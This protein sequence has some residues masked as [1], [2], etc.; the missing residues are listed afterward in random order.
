MKNI[1]LGA[2]MLIAMVGCATDKP[3][4]DKQLDSISALDVVRYSTPE[5][6]R[7]SEGTIVGGG[8]LFGGFGMEALGASAGKE[9][10]ER[11]NLAD[12]GEL[13]VRA[14]VARAPEQMPKWPRM[15]VRET[16]VE[17]V[18]SAKETYVLLFQPTT[19][20]LYIFGSL[21]GLNTGAMATLMA[22]D[23]EVMWRHQAFYS[24]MREKRGQDVEALEANSCKLLK[25]EM[26][27]AAGFM[28]ND[29]IANIRQGAPQSSAG[30]AGPSDR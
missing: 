25:E 12:F 24:Q 3:L 18:Y 4:E 5:L 8:L 16:P 17:P 26:Q 19:V 2:M 29:F 11:C 30:M 21:K 23:G 14:F 6:Q 28:A 9:L 10:R 7:H 27:Y 20:W 22:P 15:S 13:M 1:P